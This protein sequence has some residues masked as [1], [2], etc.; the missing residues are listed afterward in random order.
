VVDDGST[1][2]LESIL[3]NQ[4]VTYV[5]HLVNLGQG[6]AL[7]TG[8]EVALKNDCIEYI[9]TFDADGQHSAKYALELVQ[10]ITE[11]S[12]DIVLGSRFLSESES[13]DI[14]IKK[15]LVLKLGILFT[16]FDSGLNLTDTHN[17]LRVMTRDFA[18]SL[19]IKQ[20]GMA[21]ASEIISHIRNSDARWAEY[22][23]KIFY[24]DYA[25]KK[26]QSVFNAINIFT[27]MLHK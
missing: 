8:I 21:H 20:P 4:N 12:L 17:G 15:K 23:V 10:K 13:T 7:Q 1:D 16:R 18:Q 6:A 26:G 3:S 5:K 14:P 9:L 11:T 24:S 22:P 25:V 19:N 2:N 27:E